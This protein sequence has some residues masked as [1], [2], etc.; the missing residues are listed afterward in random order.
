[1]NV[2]NARHKGLVRF[3]ERGEVAG[4]P[5]AHLEKIRNILTFLFDMPSADELRLVSIWKAHQLSGERK[6][7]WSLHVSRNWRITFAVDAAANEIIDLDFE[8]YH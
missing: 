5:S 3:I 4:L 2:R 7:V 8:D 1:M 6:G